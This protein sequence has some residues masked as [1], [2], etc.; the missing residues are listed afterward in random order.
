MDFFFSADL[1]TEGKSCK[2]CLSIYLHYTNLIS[3]SDFYLT[4]HFH[5]GESKYDYLKAG[6]SFVQTYSLRTGSWCHFVSIGL[7]G[8]EQAMSDC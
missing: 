7:P 8:Q 1:Q 2:I 4:H 5:Q 6:V 3:D